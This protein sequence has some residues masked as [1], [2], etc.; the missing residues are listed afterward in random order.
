[1]TQVIALVED[2]AGYRASLVT[3]FGR[4]PGMRVADGFMRGE[5]FLAAL[6]TPDAASW[7]LALL[8][9]ELPGMNGLEVLR[10]TRLARADLHVVMLTAFE[11]PPLILEAICAGA[12]GYLLKRASPRE[13]VAQLV[14]VADGGAPLTAG[15]ART[16]LDLVRGGRVRADD[17]PPLTDRE[18][19]VL[20]GLCR[21]GSYK[22]IAGDLGIG[23]ETVRTHIKA[24]YRKLQVSN[25]AAAV[26]RAL[27]AGLIGR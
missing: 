23:V 2:D 22:T 3:L 1:V 11:D 19:E 24:L 7:T 17:L 4:A 26:S 8:D 20:L 10:R 15:V 6:A 12:D 18:R 16:V 21:G 13:L 25:V 5:D 27:R 9:V 14:T